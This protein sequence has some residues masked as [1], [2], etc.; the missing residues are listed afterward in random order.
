[1]HGQSGQV[2]VVVVGGGIAGSSMATVLASHGLQVAVLERQTS[3]R[4]HV[5]G[6]FMQLW[7]VAE[8]QALDL[9]GAFE[10]AGAIYLSRTV[11]YDEVLPAR[12][13]EAAARDLTQMLPGV[14]GPLCVGHPRR[15]SR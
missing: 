9:C 6:E 10:R 15:A 4:D 11:P 3:Y 13:A 5:R 1:M 12:A 14:P 8:A 7:G 2:D